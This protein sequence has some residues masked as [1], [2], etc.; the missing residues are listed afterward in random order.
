MTPFAPRR[1]VRAAFETLS[2]IEHADPGGHARVTGGAVAATARA[3]H[4]TER[5]VRAVLEQPDALPSPLR[6]D[7]LYLYATHVERGVRTYCR[8]P[9]DA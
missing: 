4:V 6:D 9:S 2:V 8:Q 5:Y 1:T 7:V 3:L